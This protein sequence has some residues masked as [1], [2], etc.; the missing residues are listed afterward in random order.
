MDTGS[1]LR[2]I[3]RPIRYPILEAYQG[4]E[5]PGGAEAKRLFDKCLYAMMKAQI[6]Y[7]TEKQINLTTQAQSLIRQNR[8]SFRPSADFRKPDL[9]TLVKIWKN[10]IAILADPARC[11]DHEV[12]GKVVK[13]VT[14]E[15]SRRSKEMLE[16]RFPWPSTKATRGN[17]SL[18]PLEVH[19]DECLRSWNTDLADAPTGGDPENRS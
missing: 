9:S 14:R 4:K 5:M 19:E 18:G 15:W 3:A 11:D 16:G 13:C 2:R 12:A 1:L 7:R 8:L 6:V 17:G 10:A